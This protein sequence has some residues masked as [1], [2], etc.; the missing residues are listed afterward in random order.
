MHATASLTEGDGIEPTTQD[1]RATGHHPMTL[2]RIR[3]LTSCS[4]HIFRWQVHWICFLITGIWHLKMALFCVFRWLV[5]TLN[6]TKV[7]WTRSQKYPCR[8]SARERL[9]FSIS[10]RNLH[11]LSAY[12]WCLDLTVGEILVTKH[13]KASLIY[14]KRTS[15]SGT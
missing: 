10:D 2:L 1:E 6:H 13:V 5:M 7:L 3:F 11:S 8:L 12:S 4:S 14:K 9:S 15:P